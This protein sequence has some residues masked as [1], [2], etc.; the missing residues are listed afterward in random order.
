M[1]CVHE[2]LTICDRESNVVDT[3]RTVFFSIRTK[4]YLLCVYCLCLRARTKRQGEWVEEE[5]RRMCAEIEAK[6]RYS[7]VSALIS[8]SVGKRV[9]VADTARSENFKCD[10][11]TFSWWMAVLCE[12]A[13]INWI[14]FNACW[15]YVALWSRLWF[16]NIFRSMFIFCILHLRCHFLRFCRTATLQCRTVSNSIESFFASY[17]TIFLFLVSFANESAM[18]F[19][20]YK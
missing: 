11:R 5:E 6:S 8:V 4:I 10:R 14:Y 1:L 18:L 12:Y 19:C 2:L 17:N 7:F 16:G 9:A 3:V 13:Q 20:Q 15:I